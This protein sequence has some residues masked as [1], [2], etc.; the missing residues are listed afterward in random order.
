MTDILSTNEIIK[1]ATLWTSKG[2]KKNAVY[3]SIAY[4]I[5]NLIRYEHKISKKH[6]IK[7]CLE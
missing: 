1:H 5:D 4:N 2:M 6:K 3:V 7:S